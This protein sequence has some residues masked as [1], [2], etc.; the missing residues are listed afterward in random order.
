MDPVI[1]NG[2]D[3]VSSWVQM[4]NSVCGG[5]DERALAERLLPLADCSTVEGRAQSQLGSQVH[6]KWASSLLTIVR[7][8][9]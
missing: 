1:G 8:Q 7:E 5:D 4:F 2:E 3:T 9:G 6:L